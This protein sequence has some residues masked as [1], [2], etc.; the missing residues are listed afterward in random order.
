MRT[1]VIFTALLAFLDP[2][3]RYS[4]FVME[5]HYRSAERVIVNGEVTFLPDYFSGAGQF[6]QG[7]IDSICKNASRL[8]VL[9][10]LLNTK[11]FPKGKGKP[12]S[13]KYGLCTRW[14]TSAPVANPRTIKRLEDGGN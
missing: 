3:L 4:P 10:R 14:G 8:S 7:E 12:V 2:L 9:R 13:R 5:A 6:N 11:T 1:V